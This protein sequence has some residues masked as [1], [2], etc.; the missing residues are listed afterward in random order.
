MINQNI[1]YIDR[2]PRELKLEIL[3]YL[4]AEDLAQARRWGKEWKNLAQGSP[5]W[6][7]FCKREFLKKCFT[8]ANASTNSLNGFA[9]YSKLKNASKQILQGNPQKHWNHNNERI[10]CIE[11]LDSRV[12]TVGQKTTRIWEDPLKS[13]SFKPLSLPLV[14]AI[15]ISGQTI[16]AV[17][18]SAN[19][20]IQLWDLDEDQS[21]GFLQGH[22]L[23]PQSVDVLDGVHI[24]SGSTDKTIRIWNLE[25]RKAIKIFEAASPILRIKTIGNMIVTYN[26]C[27]SSKISDIQFW[28]VEKGTSFNPIPVPLVTC[29]EGI[30]EHTAAYGAFEKIGILDRRTET[31]TETMQMDFSRNFSR[32]ARYIQAIDNNHIM[33]SVSD[34]VHLWDRRKSGRP[35]RTIRFPGEIRALKIVN[36]Q[37]FVGHTCT[38]WFGNITVCANIESLWQRFKGFAQVW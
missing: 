1:N 35:F 4:Q 28:D 19:D 12:V 17:L 31:E 29:I 22:L 16:A 34:E 20:G 11:A 38:Y 5:L 33:S 21:K 24:V 6:N 3:S 27:F 9:S 7:A 30:D 32:V 26:Y 25:T 15:T 37:F 18:D 13:N 23:S 36:N 14:K 8:H 2:L 10:R